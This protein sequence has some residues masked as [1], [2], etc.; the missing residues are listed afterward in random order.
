MHIGTGSRSPLKVGE[1]R[2]IVIIAHPDATDCLT[3]PPHK[4]NSELAA[5][6]RSGERLIQ[7]PVSAAGELAAANRQTVQAAEYELQGRRLSSLASDARQELLSAAV[8]YTRSYRDVAEPPGSIAAPFFLAGH[9]PEMFHP[10][11]WLKNFVLDRLARRHGGVA[12]N[13]VIDSD[14]IKS[15]SLRVPGGSMALPTAEA[16]PF[17]RPTAEIP[18]QARTI[19]DRSLFESFGRR[20]A[21]RLAPL[22]GDPLIVDYWPVVAAASRRTQNLGECLSQSRHQW[23]GRWGGQTLEIPQSGVCNL[24]AFHWLTAHVLAHLPR[25][26]D[27]YNSALACYRR[28]HHVRSTAHPVPELTAEDSWLEAPYWLWTSDD[29]RRR[30]VFVRERGDEIVLS[31]REQTEIV[32]PL[33]ADGEADRAVERLAELGSAGVFL[34]SRALLTTLSA[35]LLFGDLFLHGIGGAK[36]DRLTDAIIE[37]FFGIEPP[38]FMVVSGTLHLPTDRPAVPSDGMQTVE[39]ELRELTFH[40]ERFLESRAGAASTWIEQKRLAIERPFAPSEARARCRAIREANE[41]LQPYLEGRRGELESRAK[42]IAGDLRAEAILSSRE[43][44]FCL[45]PQKSLQTF[46][47]A[48]PDDSA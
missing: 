16:I 40:P 18:F 33:S 3:A 19:Q 43:Y 30:R 13:L 45:Y 15:S 24:S 42:R 5:P 27:V 44:G 7:P 23:E 1:L 22:V 8:A 32:L 41:N 48:F 25:F 11:V 35:R 4:L 46:L 10:G 17:D 37:R 14:T 47:L 21:E 12:I 20:V 2:E 31:D 26:W 38:S 34:R 9:Q 36:Y 29:P 39:R 28:R 6:R